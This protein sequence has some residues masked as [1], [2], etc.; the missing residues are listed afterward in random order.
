MVSGRIFVISF[1]LI[2]IGAAF[3]STLVMVN[4]SGQAR[5]NQAGIGLE[6]L[7]NAASVWALSH[8]GAYP[9]HIALLRR[10]RYFDPKWLD[11]PRDLPGIVWTVGAIDARPFMDEE[12]ALEEPAGG[13]L[14]RTPLITAVED[15]MAWRGSPIYFFGDYWFVQLP[16]HVKNESL[17]FGWSQPDD[18]GRRFVAFDNGEVRRIERGGWAHVWRNDAAARAAL[19]LPPLDMPRDSH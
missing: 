6:K 4:N 14:D 19:G 16:R 7:W 1:A 11:D 17:I 9:V 2:L 5:A 15:E 3:A 12:V 13:W 18:R 8:D 10:S